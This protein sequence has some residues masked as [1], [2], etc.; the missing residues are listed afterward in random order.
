MVSNVI[1]SI[2]HFEQKTASLYFLQFFKSL[3]GGMRADQVVYKFAVSF[4]LIVIMFERC[5]PAIESNPIN[6]HKYLYEGK[7]EKTLHLPAKR[8][9]GTI[10]T[11]KRFL[12]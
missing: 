8:S 6:M 12:V 3:H 10:R 9:Y 7:L 2:E 1:R 11:D 5:E 4:K